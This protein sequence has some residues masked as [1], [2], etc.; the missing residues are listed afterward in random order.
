MRTVN[1]TLSA[2][3]IQVLVNLSGTFL[4]VSCS[5]LAHVILGQAKTCALLL[6]CDC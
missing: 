3:T 4:L 1:L 5:P 2:D 6:R